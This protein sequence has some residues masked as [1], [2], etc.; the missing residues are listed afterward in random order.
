MNHGPLI[1]LG[2][3]A[4]FVASW[5]ALVF[6]PQL[7]IGAQQ[8][9]QTD[10][11][12]FPVRRPGLAQQGREVYVA[13]GCVQCH[14]QQVR[15]DNYNFDVTLTA[16]GTNA[17]EVAKLLHVIAPEQG[18]R[19]AEI[20]AG[21]SEKTP[22]TILQGVPLGAASSAQSQLTK[23]GATVQRNFR[24]L[25]SDIQRGWGPRRTV[26]ADYLY[27]QP[28]QVGNSRL[29]PDLSHVGARQPMAAWHLLHLYDP[30]TQVKGSMMPAYRYL[31]DTRKMGRTPSPEALRLSEGFA[32]PKDHEVIPKPEALQ[33]VAYLQSLRIEGGL[34]EAPLTPPAPVDTGTNA[35]PAAGTANP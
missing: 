19:V 17:T 4:S 32:P 24:P 10:G 31:F 26:A 6:A 3:L 1:F 14:S 22:M 35:P 7:Q 2:V 21:A 16:T 33:L 30:R 27:D 5:W 20:L 9:V 13:A 28:V 34:F 11:G 12:I 29:G 25:G 18:A 23:A 15:Q 8:T